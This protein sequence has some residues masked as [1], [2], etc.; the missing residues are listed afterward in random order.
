M[1]STKKSLFLSAISLVLCFSMLLGTTWAWFT[2]EV[3]SGSNRIVAGNLD[4]DLLMD[5]TNGGTAESYVSIAGGT[6]DIFKEADKAQ[7]SNATLWEPGK[8]QFA[9]LAVENK[10]NLA[11]KY[12]AYIDVTDNG[13]ADALECALVTAKTPIP[14]DTYTNWATV[15]AAVGEGAIH[16]VTVGRNPI[17]TGVLDE[18][19]NGTT[20]E[21]DYVLL[22][23]HMKEEA[24]NEYQGKDCIIDVTIVA[25]QK[26]AEEDAF[27]PD[28]DALASTNEPA[29]PMHE[30]ASSK[31]IAMTTTESTVT[32]VDGTAV[33]GTDDVQI[34]SGST[35]ATAT[36]PVSAAQDVMK[37][38]LPGTGV[39]TSQNREMALNLNVDTTETKVDSVT[40]EIGVTADLTYTD[41]AGK[42]QQS[43]SDVHTLTSYM[44]A[45]ISIGTGL[46]DV[47]V[48]HS[49]N[50]ME[51]MAN[52]GVTPTNEYGG[53]HYADSTG[54]LTIK[55]KSFSPFKVS[56]TLPVE[57]EDYVAKVTLNG[58]T[59]YFTE[60]DEGIIDCTDQTAEGQ[61][62]N[63]QSQALQAAFDYA[64][65]GRTSTTA[66]LVIG[67]DLSLDKY[68]FWVLGSDELNQAQNAYLAID[69]VPTVN[70]DLNGKTVRFT[71]TEKDSQQ[72]LYFA[73]CNVSFK[74]ST[75]GDGKMEAVN[76]LVVI[77]N[78]GNCV[79]TFESGKYLSAP[80]QVTTPITII[81]GSVV[82]DSSSAS[83]DGTIVMNGGTFSYRNG[84][85]NF[86]L[87]TGSWGYIH[88]GY[89]YT[90]DTT[91]CTFTVVPAN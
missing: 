51:K 78:G 64:V 3:T 20:N 46:K 9:K 48:T 11:V 7:N 14:T 84:W 31:A 8:T 10:G 21:R 91:N 81:K 72:G 45:T 43:T 86:S 87:L 83:V 60:H 30:T 67:K 16:P 53:Y 65:L 44:T 41:T 74:D 22:A 40:Y 47:K 88:E 27:G 34:Q 89:T 39:D 19:I 75:N 54:I 12:T 37:D 59:K 18:I 33:S 73:N 90:T 26:D 50:E 24:G 36:V 55:S 49:G 58:E 2:D 56:Y 42:V 66:D 5:K 68:V 76:R 38:L 80:T 25:T 29:T 35:I 28:Y 79:M 23:V 82:K 71:D 15:K 62:G 13:L 70:V 77:K 1:K 57:P 6:G 52:A 61:S 32:H 63:A 17:A 85:S 69:N 4:I